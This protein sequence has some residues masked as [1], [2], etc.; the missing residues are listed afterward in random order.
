METW[1]KVNND[2]IKEFERVEQQIFRRILKAH[3]E[4]AIEALYLELGIIPLKFKLISQT[5][6]LYIIHH[7]GTQS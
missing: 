1:C 3:S 6:L 7:K 2:K 5:L 4:T